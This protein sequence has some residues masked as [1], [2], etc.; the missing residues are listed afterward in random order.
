MSVAREARAANARAADAGRGG[1]KAASE[2]QLS[3]RDLYRLRQ[4][5]LKARESALRT[6]LAQH[7]VEALTLELEWRYRLLGHDAAIDAH[8]GAITLRTQSLENGANHDHQ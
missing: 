6:E 5:Q 3:L 4:A 2:G 8:T 1:R 7:Q